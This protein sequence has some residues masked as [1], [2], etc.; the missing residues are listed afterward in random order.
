M[1][2]RA[3]VLALCAA[4]CVGGE[5]AGAPE[6]A[7]ESGVVRRDS[8]GIE[9]V[10]VWP[11][12]IEALPVWRLAA[13]PALTIGRVEGEEPYLLSRV[14]EGVLLEDGGVVIADGY[15]E[16]A[17]SGKI[18]WFDADGVFVRRG[19]RV[20]EGPG[21]FQFPQLVERGRASGTDSAA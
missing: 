6:G 13:G 14:L 19:G 15:G 4:A 12:A 3:T 17:A 7:A 5:N 8:A 10:E 11:A 2:L 16:G 9:I 18:R 1:R 21:E 20:G